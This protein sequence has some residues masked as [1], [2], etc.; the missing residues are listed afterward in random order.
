MIFVTVGT[1]PFDALIEEMDLLAPELDDKVVCQIASGGYIPKNCGYFRT[2]PDIRDRL[3]KA[4]I[5][6][7]HGGAATIFEAMAMGKMVIAVCNPDMKERHQEDLVSHL[8]AKGCILEGTLGMMKKAL[9]SKKKP[10]PLPPAEF[11]IG[12]IQELLSSPGNP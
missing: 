9:R 7:T 8:A 4:D 10:K 11:D 2:E 5:V 6:V 3:K 12:S 1:T